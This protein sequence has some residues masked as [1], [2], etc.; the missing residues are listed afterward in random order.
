LK[1][2]ISCGEP[3]GDLYAGALAVE[4][5]HRAPGATIFGLGGQR[6]MAGGGELAADYHGLSVTGLVEA[7]SVVPRSFSMIGRLTE[8]ARSERP[9][10]AVVID[11]P[12]FHL[13]FAGL[14]L[15]PRLKALGIPVIYYIPPQLWAWRRA[16][17]RLIKRVADR[18]LVIF[19]FEEQL[20]RD[21]GIPVEF[22]GHPL[23]DLARPQEPPDVFRHAIGLDPSRPVVAL[24]PGSRRNEVQRL[25]PVMR[26]AARDIAKQSPGVQFVIARAPGLDNPLF[27]TLRWDGVRPIEVLAKTDDVL[28]VADVA[29]TASGTATVQTALHG[30]P[31][32]VVYK[33]SPMTY[34]LGR[35]FVHVDKFAMAN[36]IAGRRIVPELIQDE[37]TPAAVTREVMAYLT[38]PVRAGQTRSALREVREKLGRPGAS[39]RAADAVLQYAGRVS[40]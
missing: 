34:R 13:G 8:L 17:L 7:L 25:L 29:V 33:L 3:S 35:R 16:R 26:D 4:I 20:Y 22:V 19:P 32:V 11:F 15:A 39:G 23:I 40:R 27:S 28:A 14:G 5:R 36:L 21:A 31:M 38:D 10:V 24:L 9:D 12:D 6:L 30:V 2:M 1:I 37:C 18:V